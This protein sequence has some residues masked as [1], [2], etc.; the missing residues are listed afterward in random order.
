MWN[1]QVKWRGPNVEAAKLAVELE[2]LLH[3]VWE[4]ERWSRLEDRLDLAARVTIP[5]HAE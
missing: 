5:S 4:C 1:M 2:D 3:Q